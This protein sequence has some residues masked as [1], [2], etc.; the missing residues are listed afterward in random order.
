MW[1]RK[2]EARCLG[3]GV[4]RSGPLRARRERA[5]GWAR[6]R[7][8][9][10]EAP[11]EGWRVGVCGCAGRLRADSRCWARRVGR[12]RGGSRHALIGSLVGSLVGKPSAIGSLTKPVR[13][14]ISTTDRTHARTGPDTQRAQ[15]HNHTQNSNTRTQPDT[16]HVHTHTHSHTPLPPHSL[17]HPHAR[18][19]PPGEPSPARSPPTSPPAPPVTLY[20]VSRS[21]PALMNSCLIHTQNTRSTSL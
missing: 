8:F 12:E 2:W 1:E 11:R 20:G 5:K 6:G 16:P 7:N 10:W 15:A 18:A 3:Y 4:A 17:S 21:L 9:G 14:Q 19:H 13:F